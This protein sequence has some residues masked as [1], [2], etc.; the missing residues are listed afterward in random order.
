M[1]KEFRKNGV[2]VTEKDKVQMED[3]LLTFLFAGHDT[4]ATTI[5]FA[6]YLLAIHPEIQRQVNI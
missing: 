5:S 2:Q 1:I 6:M 3:E 4:T